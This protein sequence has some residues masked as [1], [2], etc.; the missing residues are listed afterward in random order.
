M[1][2]NNIKLIKVVFLNE[3][4]RKIK[5]FSLIELMLVLSIMAV[6]FTLLF[7]LYE[8]VLTKQREDESV[9]DIKLIQENVSSLYQT[10]GNFKGLDLDTAINANLLPINMIG[11]DGEA[12]NSFKG[13]VEIESYRMNKAA[14]NDT[15]YRISYKNIP[16]NSCINIIEN[17]KNNFYA[18]YVNKTIVKSPTVSFN[19][20]KLAKTCA[21]EGPVTGISFISV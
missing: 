20:E 11:R 18:I 7:V 6:S 16:T 21:K 3:N 10:K 19:L 13:A 9:S 14:L 8:S 2:I 1:K 15:T 4:K 17:L 5:G 12:Y